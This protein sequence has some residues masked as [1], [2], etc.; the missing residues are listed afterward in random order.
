[1]RTRITSF[2][3]R[4]LVLGAVAAVTALTVTA[5][6]I[7][8]SFTG[9][10]S[11]TLGGQSFAQSGFSFSVTVPTASVNPGAFG[12]GIPGVL[13]VVMNF[14]ISGVGAGTISN[15]FVYNNSVGSVGLGRNGGDILALSIGTLLGTY[16][17]ITPF[18]P[19]TATGRDVSSRQ[20][21]NIPTNL[22]ETLLTMTNVTTAT[23]QATTGAPV[24]PGVV[25]EPS[26]YALLGTGL[27]AIGGIARRRRT[28]A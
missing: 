13:N 20:F 4:S 16:D 5:Q 21:R 17:M 24:I 3:R 2:L 14:T 23:F 28:N 27:L 9:V 10:G 1:M 8:Y 19:V 12:V 26:T 25:P 7:T 15:I 22:S 18:G 11:G 6:N